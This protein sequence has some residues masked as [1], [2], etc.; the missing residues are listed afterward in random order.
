M[1]IN[2]KK[3]A[4]IMQEILDCDYNTEASKKECEIFA[5]AFLDSITECLANGDNVKFTG[6]GS[7][8]VRQRKERTCTNPQTGEKISVPESKS[9][10]FRA[11]KNLKAAVKGES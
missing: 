10:V 8:E 5:N 7:F 11:G 9:P 2:T 1:T 3:F 4:G 6:F